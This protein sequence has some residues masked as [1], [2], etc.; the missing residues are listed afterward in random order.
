MPMWALPLLGGSS[1]WLALLQLLAAWQHSSADEFLGGRSLVSVAEVEDPALLLRLAAE[2]EDAVGE[3]LRDDAKE[4][5][6]GFA[7]LLRPMF[8]SLPRNAH[9]NLDHSTVRYAL[10]RFFVQ[11]HGWRIDGLERVGAATESNGASPTGLLRERVPG[12]LMDVFEEAFGKTGLKQHELSIFAATLE[13]IIHDE[14]TSRLLDVYEAL[15]FSPTDALA[16]EEVDLATDAFMMSLVL[17]QDRLKSNGTIESK[18]A[19]LAKAYPGW[20]DTQLWMRDVRLTLEHLEQGSVNPFREEVSYGFKQV[21]R[22]VE[23]VSQRFGGFQ[24]TEC[25]QLKDTLLEA[26]DRDTGRV[27]LSDFYKKGL[28]TNALFKE[29]V[30]YLRQQGALDETK[31]GEPRVIVPNF[32]LS[33]GNCL[34]DTGLYSVCCIN[35]CEGLLGHIEKSVANHE[36][37]PEQLVEIVSH[38]SSSSVEA[39]R[40]LPERLVSQL[41]LVALRHGGKIPLHSRSLAQWLHIAFP[42]ECPYPHAASV[43]SGLSTSELKKQYKNNKMDVDARTQYIESVEQKEEEDAP[44]SSGAS[45]TE[46]ELLSQWSHEEEILYQAPQKPGVLKSLASLVGRLVGGVVAVAGVAALGTELMRRVKG[47]SGSLRPEKVH[48]V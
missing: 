19:R 47:V 9:G 22:V 2:V 41:E 3:S 45:Q 27:L 39:P 23:Q 36:A 26:E 30:D 48:L 10:N 44:C 24:N 6:G 43:S 40:Q 12:F 38:L 21:E 31:P 35:E 13:H 25:R 5:L 28:E 17:G 11:R 42:R 14:A 8:D 37:S 18:L 33:P 1:R 20:K 32:L 34:A 4:R 46:E 16:V 15:R 29:S 7:E